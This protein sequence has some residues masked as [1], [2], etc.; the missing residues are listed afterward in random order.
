MPQ[1]AISN[2]YQQNVSLRKIVGCQYLFYRRSEFDSQKTYAWVESSPLD[3][4]ET[5][6]WWC[7]IK[8]RI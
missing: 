6:A 8:L 1:N 3:V 5:V 7:P 4:K 2:T